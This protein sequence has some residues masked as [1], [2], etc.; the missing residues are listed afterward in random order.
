MMSVSRRAAV[1]GAL[2]LAGG[3]MMAQCGQVADSQSRGADAR[4]V[5]PRP[6]LTT[7]ERALVSLFERAAPSVVSVIAVAPNMN[8]LGRQTGGV[9]EIG[10]GS[11]F[12]WDENGHIVTNF[13]VIEQAPGILIRFA[14]GQSA[15]ATVVGVAPNQDLAVLRVTG[16]NLPAPIDIGS[17]NDLRVGQRAFAIGNP[18][19]LDQ[20]LTEGIISAL[21]RNLPTEN[22]REIDAV[23]QT[24][25]AVNPGNSG[26]PL[27]DSAGRVIGVNTAIFS[28]SG[29]SAGIG[30]AIPVDTVNRVVP[31]IVATGRVAVAGIGVQVLD[32]QN[33]A[34]L[35]VEGLVVMGVSNGGPAARAGLRGA[36]RAAVQDVIVSVN[37]QPVR[38]LLDM[39][40]I[41][42][43]VGVGGQVRLVVE[44]NGR[45]REA[46]VTVVDIGQ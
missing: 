10:G 19:G 41:V 23:I 35:G 13:H 20:T 22:G 8:M 1:L 34:R 31:Q 16:V 4:P 11:G 38:R 37:G 12:V 33:A 2:A 15:P 18:F 32:E 25:A 44:N 17:S 27:L 24:D 5:A 29:A 46:T 6:S 36:T 30:F 39:T 21:N 42:D 28:P 7:E 43:Q 40:R 14:D 26:G 9:R 45:R 3:L